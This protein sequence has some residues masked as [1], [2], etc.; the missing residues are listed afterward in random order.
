MN[1]NNLHFD[2]HL[3]GAGE[4]VNTTEGVANT[5]AATVSPYGDAQGLSDEMRTY[6]SDYLIDNAEPKLIHD[7]FAQK[8]PIPK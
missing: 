8:L 5:A 2:L 7:Q 3:F 6:Y 4:N 1:K